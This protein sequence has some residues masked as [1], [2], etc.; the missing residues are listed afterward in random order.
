MDDEKS[1][2]GAPI[3]YDP[4]FDYPAPF[5][6]SE[7]QPDERRDMERWGWLTPGPSSGTVGSDGTTSANASK[8]AI[9]PSG[10]V[11]NWNAAPPSDDWE[12]SE[13]QV[14]QFI[15]D[16]TNAEGILEIEI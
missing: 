3:G 1:P 12:P 8:P 14:Q 10:K 7:L 6:P 16:H 9:D 13:E 5:G 15:R 4:N 11:L 2:T